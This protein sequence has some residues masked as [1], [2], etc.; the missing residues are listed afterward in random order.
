MNL[1]M[2]QLKSMLVN[3]YYAINVSPVMGTEH[4]TLISKEE[5]IKA[6]TISVLQDDEGNKLEAP[7]D[8]EVRLR[9]SLTRVLD[10]LE[11]NE[12][13]LGYKES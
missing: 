7:E 2:E 9:E 13:P 4:E 8:I 1:S 12:I 3:P 6:F 10:N 11:S 5:W